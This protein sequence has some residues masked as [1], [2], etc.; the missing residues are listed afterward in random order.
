[1]R[2]FNLPSRPIAA[3]SAIALLALAAGCSKSTDTGTAG[4]AAIATSQT[5][6]APQAKA[7]SKL[8]DLSAFRSIASDV[9]AIVDKGDL[10]AAKTRIKELEIAWDAAEAG[11]KPRAADDWH[12]LDKSIDRALRALRADA[13]NQTDCKKAMSDLLI[14]FDALQ[15]KF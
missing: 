9:L 12:M 15:G 11:L 7:A 1:M 13:P 5:T 8:G 14:T 3:I 10:P 2:H 4:S 6:S